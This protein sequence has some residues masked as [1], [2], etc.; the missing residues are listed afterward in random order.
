MAKPLRKALDKLKQRQDDYD[1]L[2][3]NLKADRKRPGSMK[4]KAKPSSVT[5]KRR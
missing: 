1:R 2:P 3:A 5:G 4:K